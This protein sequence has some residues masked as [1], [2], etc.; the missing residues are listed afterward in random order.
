MTAANPRLDDTQRNFRRAIRDHWVLFLI[1][2]AV[3]ILLGL[4][5][6]AAPVIATLAVDFYAGWLFLISGIV[7]LVTLFK[8]RDLPGFFWTLIAAALAILAGLLLILRPAAGVLTLT[9]LLTAFFIVEGISQ[10]LASFKYRSVLANSWAW[11]LFSGVVDLVLAAIIIMGWPGTAAWT[12]GLLVG[13]NLLMAGLGLVMTAIACR[14][15]IAT[16]EPPGS[17]I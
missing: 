17:A 2:G 1:Q 6:I 5:A 7:G 12:L 3:M 14:S 4:F 10:I 16:H 9:L 15:V 11:M 8:R 13:I